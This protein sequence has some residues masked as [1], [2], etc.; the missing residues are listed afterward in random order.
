LILGCFLSV[1]LLLALAG[2]VFLFIVPVARVIAARN[3]RPTPCVIL[4][5]EVGVHRGS[6]GGK[7]YSIDV[8]YEYQVEGERHVSTRYQFNTGSSI[9]YDGTKAIVNRLRPGTSATCYVDRRDPS[10]AVLERGFTADIL[11]GLIPLIFV[12]VGGAVLYGVF[13]RKRTPVVWK[14]PRD[15]DAPGAAMGGGEATLKSS[16]SPAGRLGCA[17][18]FALFWNGILSMFVVE[19]VQGWIAGK[20]DGCRTLFMIPFVLVGLGMI[21]LAGYYFLTLFNPRPTLRVTPGRA[22]LGDSVEVEWET[23]GHVD[24][25]RAFSIVLEGREE[26]SYRSGKSM[27]T[28]KAIFASVEVIRSSKG[29]D[30]RRGRMKIAIPADTMHSWK[31]S[32]NKFLW[33]FQVKGDIPRWPDVN[34]EFPFEVSPLEPPGGRS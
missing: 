20:P 14:K 9:G 32:N 22:A 27:R 19:T 11:F 1:F 18:G 7:T 8:T 5:S 13:A 31:S 16:G 23:S 29:E 21:L 4:K 6:K 2:T 34:E 15:L 26:A 17:A 25:I 33:S 12:L 3:W 10:A 30:L 24:R 28:D